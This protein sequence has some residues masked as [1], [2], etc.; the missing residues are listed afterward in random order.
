MQKYIVENPG[1]ILDE[2]HKPS[3]RFLSAKGNR[4]M[5][6]VTRFTGINKVICLRRRN[7]PY[8]ET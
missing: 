1:Q 8:I 2:S 3:F 5:Q 7:F 6:S 4:K